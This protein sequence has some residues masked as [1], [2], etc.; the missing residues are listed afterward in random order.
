MEY[1]SKRNSEEIAFTTTKKAPTF[2][3]RHLHGGVRERTICHE[4]LGNVNASQDSN[5]GVYVAWDV[6]LS[7]L[8]IPG[9]IQ[10]VASQKSLQVP[11]PNGNRFLAAFQCLL[12]EMFPPP[13]ACFLF[14]HLFHSTPRYSESSV[15][16][17]VR[18]LQPIPEPE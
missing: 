5:I 13:P 7:W 10:D 18:S 3:G 14:S 11:L 12:F 1:L 2:E 8:M 4:L 15:R 17:V 9:L 16:I 6:M